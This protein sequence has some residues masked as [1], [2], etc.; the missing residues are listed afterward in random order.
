MISRREVMEEFEGL[1]RALRVGDDAAKG[2]AAMTLGG[3]AYRDEAACVAIA[4][5]GGI[6]P[7]VEV[8]RNGS[9]WAKQWG[10]NF[11]RVSFR[12]K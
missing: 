8:L 9:A 3:C 4:A 7:L 12:P 6:A 5:A 10:R 2:Q 1:V 11:L